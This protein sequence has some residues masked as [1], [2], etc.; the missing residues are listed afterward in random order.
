MR[1]TFINVVNEDLRDCLPAIKCPTLL[2]W[3]ERDVDVPVRDA[4]LMENMIPN[5][6]LQV[7]KGAG[8][9]CYLDDLPAFTRSVTAFLTE[10]P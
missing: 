1:R 6:R 3:G 5:A 7:L 8:H 4:L 2:V 10:K 9:F